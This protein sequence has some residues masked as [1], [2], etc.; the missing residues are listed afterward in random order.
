MF[1]CGYNLVVECHASDLVARVRFSLPAPYKN[2]IIKKKPVSKK[3][4]GFRSDIGVI[5]KR[6][7]YFFIRLRASRAKGLLTD[8]LNVTC[9]ANGLPFIASEAYTTPL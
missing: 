2:E 5:K 4:T 6:K 9:H 1:L 3:L 8:S 7:Y